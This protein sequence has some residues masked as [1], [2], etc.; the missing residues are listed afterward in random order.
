MAD[1]RQ[2]AYSRTAG[3]ALWAESKLTATR[4]VRRIT[5]REQSRRGHS[6]AGTSVGKTSAK[7]PPALYFLRRFV[8]TS[9]V[10]PFE[11]WPQLGPRS[12][13]RP[14]GLGKESI[15][16]GPIWTSPCR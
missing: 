2:D 5:L 6:A 1:D 10:L 14:K 16:D 7:V 12:R 8:Y 13:L 9:R 11:A 4:R 15:A 3:V